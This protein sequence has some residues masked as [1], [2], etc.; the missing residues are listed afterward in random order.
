VL[1]AWDAHVTHPHLPRTLPGLIRDAGFT[2]TDTTVM[3]LLNG[4][5]DPNTYSAGAIPIIAAFVTGRD[6]ITADQATSW[7]QEL[8]ELDDRYFFSLNRDVFLATTWFVRSPFVRWSAGRRGQA[9]WP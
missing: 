3:P 2:L 5:Y 6:G 7:A 4:R 1:A 8:T 9:R